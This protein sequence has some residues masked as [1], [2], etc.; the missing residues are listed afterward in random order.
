MVGLSPVQSTGPTKTFR[1]FRRWKISFVRPMQRHVPQVGICF[2]HQIIAQALGGKV[3][4][5]KEG[6]CVGRVEYQMDGETLPLIAWH[7]DQVIEPPEAARVLVQHGLL[8]IRSFGLRQSR[9]HATAASR[10]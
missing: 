1:S 5:F 10:V 6:W 4:K 8:Q 9:L 3:E 7:Q 2:G